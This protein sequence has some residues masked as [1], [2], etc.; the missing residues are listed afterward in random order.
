M[1]PSYLAA[2]DERLRHELYLQSVE[3]GQQLAKK[4]G[5]KLTMVAT[6]AG[7]E[8]EQFLNSV[9]SGRLYFRN[10]DGKMEELKYV[11][12]P[13]DFDT[14]TGEV[15]ADVGAGE[16]PNHL[17]IALASGE[18]K[19]SRQKAMEAVRAILRYNNL[20]TPKDWGK[21]SVYREMKKK[22]MA[23]AEKLEEQMGDAQELELITA[24]RRVE[25]KDQGVEFIEHTD[26]D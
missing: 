6:E 25:M 12:P 26:A 13:L 11:Q 16:S 24:D 10:K 14:D 9:G 17:M 4:E 15:A 8:D 22:I 21:N 18:R 7:K 20:W 2:D 1:Q 3:R 19:I 5:K 23:Y